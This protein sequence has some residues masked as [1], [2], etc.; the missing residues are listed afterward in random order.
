MNIRRISKLYFIETMNF[1]HS[2]TFKINIVIVSVFNKLLAA[3]GNSIIV[4]L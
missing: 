3:N 1:M 4:K 2:P